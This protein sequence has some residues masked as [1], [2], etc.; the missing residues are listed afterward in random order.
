M[1]ISA[2]NRL[3]DDLF[4]VLSKIF[5]LLSPNVFQHARPVRDVYGG[6]V[7]NLNRHPYHRNLVVYYRVCNFRKYFYEIPIRDLI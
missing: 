3:R 1:H 7:D 2:S 5:G 6:H 4:Y